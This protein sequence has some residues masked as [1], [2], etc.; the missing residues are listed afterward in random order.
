MGG[1]G[2][3]CELGGGKGVVG[4]PSSSLISTQRRLEGVGVHFRLGWV[5]G[6]RV[7]FQGEEGT[8]PWYVIGSVFDRFDI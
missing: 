1:G 3:H 7:D 2:G 5:E 4:L 6:T 8:L